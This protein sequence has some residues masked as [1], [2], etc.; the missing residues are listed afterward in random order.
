MLRQF[1]ERTSLAD[2]LKISNGDREVALVVPHGAAGGRGRPSLSPDLFRRDV[3]ELGGCASQERSPG[4]G[5]L[6]GQQNQA[7]QQEMKGRRIT[8]WTRK[9][10]DGSAD[11]EHD[12]PALDMPEGDRR[13][14]GDQVGF[15]RELYIERLETSRDRVADGLGGRGCCC[16]CRLVGRRRT[17]FGRVARCFSPGASTVGTRSRGVPSSQRSQLPC[18]P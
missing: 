18:P 1:R 10:L 8:R 2:D 4:D 12:V 5:P 14:P 16:R 6:G 15:A 7:V 13:E 9:A 3:R 11:L 17:L